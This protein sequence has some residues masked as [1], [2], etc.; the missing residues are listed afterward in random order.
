MQTPFEDDMSVK[1]EG[2]QWRA[3]GHGGGRLAEVAFP[4]SL[5][6]TPAAVF[7]Q[8]RN[9]L[10][11]TSR[12]GSLRFWSLHACVPSKRQNGERKEHET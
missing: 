9:R 2:K 11:D 5:F 12:A 3:M 7:A 10:R 4:F 8:V 6:F 1:H